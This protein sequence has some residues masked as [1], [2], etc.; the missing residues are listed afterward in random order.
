MATRTFLRCSP[1]SEE[2]ASTIA[3]PEDAALTAVTVEVSRVTGE[4]GEAGEGGEVR[5][6]SIAKVISYLH[7]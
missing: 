6:V 3:A 4:G 2:A 5:V 7:E 1:L